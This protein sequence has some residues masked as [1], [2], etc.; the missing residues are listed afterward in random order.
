MR[1]A[2][3][4]ES[5]TAEAWKARAST[6]FDAGLFSQAEWAFIKAGCSEEAAISRAYTKRENADLAQSRNSPS[7]T[8]LYLEAAHDFLQRAD[9]N[10]H[11]HKT[12]CRI[13]AECFEA[14]G[15]HSLSGDLYASVESFDHA[16]LQYLEVPDIDRAMDMLSKFKEPN[17]PVHHQV[18]EAAKLVYLQRK[19]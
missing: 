2:A 6:L 12:Y 19:V 17:D 4:E 5:H 16:A 11:W 8:N 7:S 13:A 9:C 18:T 1:L 10:P 3:N 14:A 15:H